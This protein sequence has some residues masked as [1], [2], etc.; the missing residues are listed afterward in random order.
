MTVPITANTTI[1]IKKF[2]GCAPSDVPSVEAVPVTFAG[3][4]D[5]AVPCGKVFETVSPNCV[6]AN[7]EKAF[8]FAS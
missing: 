5:W 8:V 6:I 4:P 3:S 1:I 7:D 2:T